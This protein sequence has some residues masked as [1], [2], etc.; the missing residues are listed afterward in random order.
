M[1]LQRA[2]RELLQ[3]AHDCEWGTRTL[4]TG[5]LSAAMNLERHGLGK[6][7]EDDGTKNPLRHFQI[8]ER[9]R[10]VVEPPPKPGPPQPPDR[11]G[12]PRYGGPGPGTV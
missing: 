10:E 4:G 6:I 3:R 12:K 2:E 5:E 1:E 11:P 8:N 7:V 9:G